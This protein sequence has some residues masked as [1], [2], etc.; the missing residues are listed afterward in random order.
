VHRLGEAPVE[1]KVNA[2]YSHTHELLPNM[3]IIY[4]FRRIYVRHFSDIIGALHPVGPNINA[5]YVRVIGCHL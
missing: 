1:L 2:P 3:L 4:T 5:F